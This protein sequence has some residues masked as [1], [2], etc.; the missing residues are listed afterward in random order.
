MDSLLGNLYL[1]AIQLENIEGENFDGLLAKH[2]ICQYSPVKMLHYTVF[3]EVAIRY[4]IGNYNII[5]PSLGQSSSLQSNTISYNKCLPCL[6]AL[7]IL[8]PGL[9]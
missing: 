3:Q 5:N 1:I 9:K 6:K 8:T 2:Q 4:F 7:F